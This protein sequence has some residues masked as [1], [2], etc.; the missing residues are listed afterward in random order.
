MRDLRKALLK[1]ALLYFSAGYESQKHH[2]F[3]YSSIEEFLKL[4]KVESYKINVLCAS[5]QPGP[6]PPGHQQ[7]AALLLLSG[8]WHSAVGPALQSVCV[9][10]AEPLQRRHLPQL[11]PRRWHH[12]QVPYTQLLGGWAVSLKHFW[13]SNVFKAACSLC[14]IVC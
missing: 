8:L 2:V 10:A 11:Q 12:G 9:C 14:V 13:L 1:K 4:V 6:V 3:R 7:A 5:L